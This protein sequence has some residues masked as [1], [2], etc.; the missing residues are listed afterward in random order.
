MQDEIEKILDISVKTKEKEYYKIIAFGLNM[1]IWETIATL[2]KLIRKK[3][4]FEIV[5][6]HGEILK[7]KT[8]RD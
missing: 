1:I 8:R 3:I 5:I 6:W 7:N 2:V 4:I